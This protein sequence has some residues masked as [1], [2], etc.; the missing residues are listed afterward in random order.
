MPLHTGE[1]GSQ[2]LCGRFSCPDAVELLTQIGLGVAMALVGMLVSLCIGDCTAARWVAVL[3]LFTSAVM[4]PLA[5]NL[6]VA[7][8]RASDGDKVSPYTRM[9]TEIADKL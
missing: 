5:A 3:F 1:R 4:V 7:T 2:L 8:V 6:V 9:S